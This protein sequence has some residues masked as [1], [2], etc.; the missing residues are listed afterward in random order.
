MAK[1]TPRS[2]F[3]YKSVS[4]K[5]ET[6]EVHERFCQ[7]SDNINSKG[8]S[9]A[10]LFGSLRETRVS[11]KERLSGW[12]G[13]FS[14]GLRGRQILDNPNLSAHVTWPFP[15]KYF[16]NSVIVKALPAHCPL[17]CTW[18]AAPARLRTLGMSDPQPDWQ[19]RVRCAELGV[20]LHTHGQPALIRKHK[21]LPPPSFSVPS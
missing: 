17:L 12:M 9:M 13:A 7:E 11:G 14:T 2:S 4:Q 21:F 15:A 8:I 6:Q 1:E 19:G 3:V 16:L 10:F 5:S 18:L 20:L